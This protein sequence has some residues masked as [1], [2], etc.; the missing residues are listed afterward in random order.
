MSITRI[1]AS[2]MGALVLSTA[3]G[4]EAHDG[5]ATEPLG[6]FF[7]IRTVE[8]TVGGGSHTFLLDTGGGVTTISPALAEAVGCTPWSQING[9]RMG[10]ERLSMPRC[11]GVAL[12]IAGQALTVPSAGVFDLSPLLPPGSANI[13]GLVALDVL[14]AR[15]FTLELASGRLTF[16]TPE[17]LSRRTASAI[18]VPIRFHRQGGGIALTVMAQVTTDQGAL[19]LQLDSGSDAAIQVSL[20]SAGPLGLSQEGRQTATLSFAGSGGETVVATGPV[21]VRD[22][23]IDGNVGAPVLSGWIMTFDLANQKLWVQPAG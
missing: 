23:I 10:G 2:C 17:S 15:P 5:P 13:E 9:F 8:V 22:M 20:T 1:L 3:W 11:D 18:D 21:R 14:A 7:G 6:D 19:W 4:A 12:E 16:E